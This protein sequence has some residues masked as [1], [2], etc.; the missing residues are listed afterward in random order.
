KRAI[1]LEVATSGLGVSAVAR[2]HDILPQQIYAW[3]RAFRLAATGDQVTP[4]FLPVT[5]V[6]ASEEPPRSDRLGDCEKSGRA[7]RGARIEIRCKGGRGW[8]PGTWCSST[9]A[10]V[11]A[12][13]PQQRRSSRD[14][15][16][17]H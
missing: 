8:R 14:D 15:G 12:A 6:P 10:I 3:R 4:S 1:L 16:G 5:I 2:Q 11:P 7:I 9:V 13:R 17:G